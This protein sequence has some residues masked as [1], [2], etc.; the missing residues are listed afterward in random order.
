MRF[1]WPTQR[2]DWVTKRASIPAVLATAALTMAIFLPAVTVYR[3]AH[4]GGAAEPEARVEQVTF[5]QAEVPRPTLLAPPRAPHHLSSPSRRRSIESTPR[6][7]TSS[8]TTNRVEAVTTTEVPATPASAATEAHSS[9]RERIGPVL[10]PVAA[11]QLVILSKAARD[12]LDRLMAGVWDLRRPLAPTAAQR[13]STARESDQRARVARDEHRPMAVPLG[14]SLPFTFL[15][16]GPSREQRARD[17][18]INDDYL[19]RLARLA[20]RA[21]R[22]RDSVLAANTLAGRKP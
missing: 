10:A 3:I 5:V 8:I 16:K 2:Y 21:R 11:S 18:V 9:R 13:D 1:V 12:S 14:G 6:V 7:D 20:E 15:S 22:K 17:S 19:Q 4:R